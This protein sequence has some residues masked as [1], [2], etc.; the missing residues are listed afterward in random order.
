MLA[1]Q[2]V[3]ALSDLFN[4]PVSVEAYNQMQELQ[5]ELST[6]V[7]D[8][9]ND[10]WTYI[11]G[12]SQFLSSKAYRILTG[13]TQVDPIF[14]WLW[15]TSCQG[16]HKVFFWLVLKDRLSTRNMIRRRG[17]HIEDYQCVLCQQSSEETIVH[18]LFYCPFAKDCWGLVN[19]QFAYHLTIPQIFQAWKTLLKVDFSLDIFILFCWAVWMMRN[20]VIFRN[21]NPSGRLQK[22]HYSGITPATAQVES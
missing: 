10:S 1:V 20:D 6:L 7:L 14:K 4:L 9:M 15:K 3:V 5:F 18:L 13:H 17:M 8:D 12:S 22:I 2:F 19:F 16:K 21:K 11:W